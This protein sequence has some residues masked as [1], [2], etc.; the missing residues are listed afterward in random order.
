MSSHNLVKGGGFLPGVALSVT[1]ALVAAV[2][3]HQYGAPAMLMGLLLGLWCHFLSESDRFT[4]GLV[5]ASGPCLRFGV[6]L[7][8]L[9]LSL[10]DVATLGWNAIGVVCAAAVTT[11]LFGV[12][13]A[14]LLG[15]DRHLGLLTGGAVGICGASA[16]MAISAVLPESEARQRQTLFTVIG[17]ATFSTAAMIFYPIAGDLFN[18]DSADMGLFIGA[19]IHDVAQVVGAGYSV[20]TETGDLA[21]FVK[22]V[23]VA[24][25]GPIVMAIAVY[26][27]L[28]DRRDGGGVSTRPTF[29]IFLV[30]FVGLFA[31]NNVIGIPTIVTD[32][33]SQLATGL[34][35]LA[36]TALGVRTSL[37]EVAS[38]GWRPICLLA[39]ET[40]FLAVIILE[41]LMLSGA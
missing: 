5:W 29:P 38:I 9:R 16:A 18:F 10:G 17:V 20:S 25:L 31:L 36:V 19:T 26:C 14:R 6:A 12:M 24:M 35:L 23:R 33:L 34:L 11:V 1:L 3:A 13:W 22:L 8:G 2:I 39:G 40:V 7:L 32:G 41:F 21:T 4:P 30:G 15:C 28:K 37:R 27:Q